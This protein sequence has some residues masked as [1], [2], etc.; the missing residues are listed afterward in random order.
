M[1]LYWRR[2]KEK[3]VCFHSIP[4]LLLLFLFTWK[5][6]ENEMNEKKKD[7]NN[8]IEK[9]LKEER[10]TSWKVQSNLKKPRSLRNKKFRIKKTNK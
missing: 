10:K 6:F 1:L 8:E 9:Q 5:G 2:K 4:S 3:K 7:N